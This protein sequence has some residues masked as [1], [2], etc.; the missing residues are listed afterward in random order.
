M[1]MLPGK[2]E[3]PDCSNFDLTEH[4]ERFP[5][6]QNCVEDFPHNE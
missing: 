6:Q 5:C 4:I 2:G 3:Q 1:D